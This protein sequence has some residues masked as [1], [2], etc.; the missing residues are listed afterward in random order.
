MVC[1]TTVPRVA[2]MAREDV[3]QMTAR[4]YRPRKVGDGDAEAV[5]ARR[6]ACAVGRLL[7]RKPRWKAAQDI[8]FSFTTKS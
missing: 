5:D 1:D 7:A 3:D 8:I 6:L 2:P 4:R